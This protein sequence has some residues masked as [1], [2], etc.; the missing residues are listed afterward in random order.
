MSCL[1][2]SL[3]TSLKALKDVLTIHGTSLSNSDCHP[4]DM[5][6]LMICDYK[7]MGKLI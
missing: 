4:D 2:A 1:V 3:F 6:E 5:F 7:M